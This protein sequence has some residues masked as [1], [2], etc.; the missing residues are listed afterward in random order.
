MVNY[1]PKIE[2]EFDAMKNTTLS[3]IESLAL[4]KT[5]ISL[6]FDISKHDVNP[7]ELL[8]INREEDAYPSAFNIYNRLQESI[9][10]GG[11]KLKDKLTQKVT[12]SRPITAIDEKI[13][14]N[15]KLHK[16]MQNLMLLKNQS[17][18]MAA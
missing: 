3:D 16:T 6:R 13:K 17:Y 12:T 14:L 11:I 18:Q 9:L 10:N 15:K 5:A 4:S 2:K 7:K 8:S 1:I